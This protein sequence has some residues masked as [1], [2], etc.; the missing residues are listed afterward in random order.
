MNDVKFGVWT[1]AESPLTV[2]YSLVVVEEIRREVADGY[3][4]LSRGGI[5]V[6]GALYGTRDGRTVRVLAMRTIACEHARGPGFLLSERDRT[7]LHEQL[8][9]DK[10][11][12]ALEGLISVGWFLSHTRSEILL[13]EP[14]QEIYS[15]Y[16]AAPWEVTL[17]VRPGRGGSMRAGFF[18]RKDDGTVEAARS[19]LEF[20]FPDRLSGPLPADRPPRERP[21]YSRPEP[22]PAPA[23]VERAV[24]VEQLAPLPDLQLLR[25]APPRRKWPLLLAWVGIVLIAAVMGLRYWM[26]SGIAEPIS[27]AVIE[28][29]GQLQI[30]WNHSAKPV[31]AAIDGSL[32]IVDG[33]APL[34]IKLTRQDLSDGKFTYVRKT[35]DIQVRMTVQDAKGEK[36]EE[37]SRFLG[38]PPA[39]PP[40]PSEVTEGQKLRD[41][42]QAEIVRLKKTNGTQAARIQQL[43]RTVRILETRL[44][45]EQGKQ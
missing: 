10:E 36:T 24:P 45:F 1:A 41:D 9:R 21:S 20:S 4:R 26:T 7:A 38:P 29:D 8:A 13:N 31:V 42:L 6:G 18:V 44:G 11:D 32:E 2:E 35:G 16:F 43:E 3:Q 23:P 14:D 33:A 19:P 37:A 39:P 12:P 28:H 40:I 15:T 34:N 30:S 5:E 17:V 27:L 22:S 25:P